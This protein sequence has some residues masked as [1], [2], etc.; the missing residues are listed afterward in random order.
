[1][2]DRSYKEILFQSPNRTISNTGGCRGIS[3]FGPEVCMYAKEL[4]NDE[5]IDLIQK[6][7]LRLRDCVQR[8]RLV[9]K[10]TGQCKKFILVY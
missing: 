2:F 10:T 6:R 7:K 3:T 1:V 5:H 9:H 4:G 8:L